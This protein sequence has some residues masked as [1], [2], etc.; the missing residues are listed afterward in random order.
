MVTAPDS[1]LLILLVIVW[2]LLWCGKN[3]SA[4]R[5]LGFLVVIL[6]IVALFPVGEWVLYPLEKRFPANP[7]LPQKID[8][9]IVLSGP[10]NANLSSQWNQAELGDATERLFAFQA[11]ARRYPEAKLVFTGGSGSMAY[12]GH[13]GSDVAKMLFKQQGMNSSPVIFESESR[14]TYENAVFSKVLAKPVSGE[15]WILITSAY[16]M[17][18]S[19]GVFCRAGWPMIPYPV[20]HYT[21][22]EN[23][24][25]VD[26][27]L[28]DHLRILGMGIKEWLGLV[29]YYVTGKTTALFPM[30]C[31]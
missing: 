9:I 7:V 15:N 17:P 27:E 16:H 12:Q 23:L 30:S 18:R 22:P 28:A 14:N 20:D 19:I 3:R 8:G 24:F 1:L 29:V 10:E 13:K 6:L 25:R 31:V 5:L 26:L 21:W 2:M 4:K 11:L